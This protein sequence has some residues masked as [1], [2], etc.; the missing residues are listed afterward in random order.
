MTNKTKSGMIIDSE[1]FEIVISRV[2]D[3]PRALVFKVYTDPKMIPQHWGPRNLTTVID[4]LD[5]RPGG[6]WRFVQHDPE[7]NEFAFNG[8]YREVT[9]PERLVYSFEF[10]GMPGHILEETITFEEHG[11]KT[12]LTARDVFHSLEDLNGMVAAGMEGGVIESYERLAEL[13]QSLQGQ[14]R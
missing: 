11:G 7:G 12:T 10:E 5:L 14:A 2:F 6:V 3:A 1:K 4:K 13:L 8:V 9:P